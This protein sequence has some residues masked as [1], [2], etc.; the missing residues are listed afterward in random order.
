M[1]A[2]KNEVFMTNALETI[3]KLRPQTYDK[4]M[5]QDSSDNT[6]QLTDEYM[7]ES[8]FIAQE[9]YYDVPE[10]RHLITVP[11]DADLSGN[12]IPTSSDPQID[13]D[14][15]N[16]GSQPASINYS[17]FIPYLTK[18]MQEQQEM[19]EK[20]TAKINELEKKIDK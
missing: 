15:S 2:L 14:Y 9:I 16:W 10:L 5:T 18:G 4:Y 3:A 17:G 19:I 7:R 13:P 6:L 1:N 11:K 20:L 8:G 12:P